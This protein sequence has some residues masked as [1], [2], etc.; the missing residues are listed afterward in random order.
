MAIL[1]L[2]GITL[3][4]VKSS[5]SNAYA[6]SISSGEIFR[7]VCRH[8]KN[9]NIL[10]VIEGKALNCKGFN[11]DSFVA[12]GCIL[13]NPPLTKTIVEACDNSDASLFIVNGAVTKTA[14]ATA[15]T[16]IVV[17]KTDLQKEKDDLQKNYFNL[18]GEAKAAADA[19]LAAIEV[20]LKS[21]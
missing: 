21:A 18:K 5:S 9:G 4:E 16:D 12:D 13:Y 10:L 3:D 19:R 14:P 7:V 6:A 17:S 15:T 20:A 1:N 11:G 8:S 2:N